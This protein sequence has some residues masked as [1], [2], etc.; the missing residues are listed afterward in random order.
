MTGR[1]AGEDGTAHAGWEPVPA[2]SLCRLRARAGWEHAGKRVGWGGRVV[3]PWEVL[4][5]MTWGSHSA[6]TT[7]Q[8]LPP[9]LNKPIKGTKLIVES[10]KRRLT[11][12]GHL[13]KEGQRVL[14]TSPSLSLRVLTCL[15]R[16]QEI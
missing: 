7:S 13:G 11:Q 5:L 10:R 3:P 9:I 15:N 12:C 8:A 14:M 4:L 2:G 1:R 16:K 6:Q